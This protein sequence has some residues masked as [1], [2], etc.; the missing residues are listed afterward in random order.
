M[1]W[2]DLLCGEPAPEHVGRAD[3]PRRLGGT[4]RDHGGLVFVDLRDHTGHLPARDQPRARARGA[5][6]AHEL[7][8]EFVAPGRGRGRRARARRRQ[9]EP[10]DRRGRAPGRHARDRLA[11]DAAAVPAR[12]GGRRRDAA[13]ALPL[14][15]PAP[16]AMQR[17]LRLAHMV[18]RHP[19]DDG[20][21][22]ASSTSRRRSC[23]S[24]RPRAR[25]TSSCRSGSSPAA[26]SRCRSRP[27]LF[28][29]LLM[30]GGF[31]RY[32]QIAICLRDEDLRADRVRSSA[33]STS[34]W[35]SSTRSSS[36]S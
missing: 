22:R 28:K 35:R 1:S 26:S 23:S 31:D 36:S 27:Q 18:V 34:R 19:A 9:P 14:A 2:R 30:I 10:A 3:R 25:A 5:R 17:N 11:L 13:P 8:N 33:S 21:R 32:Y 29:Q 16:R 6:V 4:R 7:R 24:R 20:R 15:R 12:R